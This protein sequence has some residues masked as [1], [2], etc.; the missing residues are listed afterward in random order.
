[1]IVFKALLLDSLDIVQLASWPESNHSSSF[2]VFIPA[3]TA[4]NPDVILQGFLDVFSERV[5][6]FLAG[7]DGV[8]IFVLDPLDQLHSVVAQFIQW[9]KN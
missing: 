3:A 2:V 9:P 7:L 6:D 4:V 5:R 8:D 1:M